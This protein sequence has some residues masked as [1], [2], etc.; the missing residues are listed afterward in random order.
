MPR[1][2]EQK[3]ITYLEIF[4]CVA[5]VTDRGAGTGGALLIEEKMGDEYMITSTIFNSGKHK[6]FVK[7]RTLRFTPENGMSYTIQEGT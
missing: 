3:T 2:T 4:D 5:L 1:Y 7:N 6:L